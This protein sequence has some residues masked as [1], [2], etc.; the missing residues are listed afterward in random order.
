L[1]F[2]NKTIKILHEKKSQKT[3]QRLAAARVSGKTLG[4]PKGVKNKNRV[5]DT[6]NLD[7][8]QSPFCK[9]YL[10]VSSTQV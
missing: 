6:Y 1:H 3:K 2:A 7:T 10:S 4:R 8:L 9:W 5:L